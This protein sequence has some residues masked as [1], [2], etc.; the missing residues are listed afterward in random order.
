MRILVRQKSRNRGGLGKTKAVSDSSVWKGFHNSSDEFGG[1]RRAAIADPADLC[2]I[3]LTEILLVNR[4]PIDCRH[5]CQQI[6]SLVAN[7]AKK[8]LHL[9][10]RHYHKRVAGLTGWKQ[11]AVAAGDVKE[12]D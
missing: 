11:L 1:D 4:K 6:N 8:R 9:E 3:D 12:R 2:R 7:C 5:R 10:S